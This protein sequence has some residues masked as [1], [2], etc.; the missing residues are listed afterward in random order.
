[1]LSLSTFKLCL[2]S[3]IFSDQGPMGCHQSL[4]QFFGDRLGFNEEWHF[5]HDCCGS[6]SLS[7][8]CCKPPICKSTLH[9]QPMVS[10]NK[11]FELQ[12]KQHL[13]VIINKTWP[14]LKK[15]DD[16][17]ASLTA[18]GQFVH[19]PTSSA[20]MPGAIDIPNSELG[21]EEDNDDMDKPDPSLL[22]SQF[23]PGP[24]TLVS[25][26]CGVLFRSP[27]TYNSKLVH[28]YFNTNI[29]SICICHLSSFNIPYLQPYYTSVG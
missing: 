8:V 28:Q 24:T 18:T 23:T 16:I 17:M 10:L 6:S 4:L 13:P 5:L 22:L 21:V 11:T 12:D 27:L 3:T 26:P 9:F 15:L 14:L 20:A 1:M 7:V 2:I 19:A 29:R 25:T